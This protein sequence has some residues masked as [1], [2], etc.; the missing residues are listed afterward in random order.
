MLPANLQKIEA[1]LASLDVPGNAAGWVEKGRLLQLLER[2]TS[3][4]S[5]Y[6]RALA[7][8]PNL[9][10]AWMRKAVLLDELDRTAEALAAYAA[11]LEHHPRH[12][13]GW[14]NRAG[15]LL[16]LGLSSE[17][18]TAAG[19]ALV[20]AKAAGA[21][22]YAWRAQIALGNYDEALKLLENLPPTEYDATRGEI[23]GRF[24]PRL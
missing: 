1:E 13:A 15:L 6:D 22:R 8:E 23:A 11:L 24:A 20:E 10:S 17:A 9:E 12:V 21:G 18:E 19:E 7:L 4:L 2:N 14:S 3:A 5:A 16:A